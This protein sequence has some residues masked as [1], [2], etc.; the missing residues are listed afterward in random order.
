MTG[1]FPAV[2]FSS[3]LICFGV[4]TEPS[5]THQPAGNRRRGLDHLSVWVGKDILCL[6]LR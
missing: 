6:L 3:A 1:L 4:A 5:E 2:V